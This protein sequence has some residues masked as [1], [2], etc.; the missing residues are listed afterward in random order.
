MRDWAEGGEVERGMEV[1]NNF[2]PS[3]H[4]VTEQMACE[5]RQPR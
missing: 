2:A 4:A 3:N 1:A 5:G